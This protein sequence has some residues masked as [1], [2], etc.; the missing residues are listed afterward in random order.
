M[1]A[2]MSTFETRVHDLIKEFSTRLIQEFRTATLDELMAASADV[3]QTTAAKPRMA[4]LPKLARGISREDAI[5]RIVAAV[6]AHPGIQAEELR[7]ST[8]L[9]KNQ[10]VRPLSFAVKGKQIKIVGQKRGAKYYPKQK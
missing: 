1:C 9:T 3:R 10:L 4:P 2:P 6:K 7:E 5:E 8:G